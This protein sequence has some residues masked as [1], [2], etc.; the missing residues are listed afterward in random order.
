MIHIAIIEDEL[1]YQNLIKQLLDQAYRE[2]KLAFFVDV[3]SDGEDFMADYQNQYDLIF[4]DI[5]MKHMNGMDTAKN[6]RRLDPFV[7]LIFITNL[8]DYAIEGYSVNAS[9]YLL[10]PLGYNDFKTALLRALEKIRQHRKRF[11]QTKTT[12]GIIKIDIAEITYIETNSHKVI[13][14]TAKEEFLCNEPMKVMEEK[15]AG[16][17]F[18]RIHSSYLI[19]LFYVENVL[20]SSVIVSGDDLL[21]SRY[22]RKDFLDA[23]TRYIGGE[24]S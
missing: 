19:N 20:T 1:A 10:K 18:Y 16:G 5:H 9:G 2:L 17:N 13:L 7:M 22:K 4:L 23:L 11:I 24:L 12:N 6:I 8:P 15:L 14:H 3:F 21:L